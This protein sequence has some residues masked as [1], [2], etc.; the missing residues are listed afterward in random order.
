[1]VKFKIVKVEKRSWFSFSIFP[2]RV[3]VQL[4]DGKQLTVPSWRPESD[5]FLYHIKL[6]IKARII[7]MKNIGQMRLMELE[8]GRIKLIELYLNKDFDS[9]NVDDE[10]KRQ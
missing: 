5:S 8:E 6:E 10:V 1:M 3:T 2:Y 7:D 4:E 9:E